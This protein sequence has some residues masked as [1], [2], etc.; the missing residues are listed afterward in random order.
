[1]EQVINQNAFW[2]LST[3]RVGVP[4]FEGSIPTD[5]SSSMNFPKNR[6]DFVEQAL[7]T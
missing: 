7:L 2:D 3:H 1:M 6:F 4:I 5:V